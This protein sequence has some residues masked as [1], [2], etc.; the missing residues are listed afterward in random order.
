MDGYQSALEIRKKE[1]E[2]EGEDYGEKKVYIVA[3]S[4]DESKEHERRCRMA[5]INETIAKPI[6]RAKLEQLT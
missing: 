3:L 2:A 1:E 5:E 4:G 6:S